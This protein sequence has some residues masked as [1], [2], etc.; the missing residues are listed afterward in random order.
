MGKRDIILMHSFTKKFQDE[1][2]PIMEN[3][4]I[5]NKKNH[6]KIASFN[7]NWDLLIK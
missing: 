2:L 7:K 5:H 4:P 6:T 1:I 3:T